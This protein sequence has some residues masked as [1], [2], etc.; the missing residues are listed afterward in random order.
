MNKVRTI[1]MSL[2][3]VHRCRHGIRGNRFTCCVKH[4]RQSQGARWLA[5][6]GRTSRDVLAQC[7][8]KCFQHGRDLTILHRHDAR[9]YDRDGV[10]PDACANDRDVA[11]D[12]PM[13]QGAQSRRSLRRA[14]P[15]QRGRQRDK[16]QSEAIR[17]NLLFRSE[18]LKSFCQTARPSLSCPTT[19]TQQQ[20]PLLHPTS[21]ETQ[22]T[23]VSR[24]LRTGK[25]TRCT[26]TLTS[27]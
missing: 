10:S 26:Q 4:R 7:Q 18:H 21:C 5:S 27:L 11:P 9:T 15:S 8:K 13:Q 22:S 17:Y 20:P 2:A 3:H 19:T 14:P 12:P 6:A 16:E 25:H 1:N 24:A 23:G